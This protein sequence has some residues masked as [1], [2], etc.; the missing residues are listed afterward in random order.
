[1]EA[2]MAAI[3]MWGLRKAR[4]ILVRIL[5]VPSKILT[6]HLPSKSW[7]SYRLGHLIGALYFRISKTETVARRLTALIEFIRRFM[8]LSRQIPGYSF[9]LGSNRFLL[10]FSNSYLLITVSF[11]AK[12]KEILRATL[13]E[14]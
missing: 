6:T 13:N 1:M 10:H 14:P 8:S 11:V 9:K 5:C 12:K 7:K 2:I 4:K 3:Y